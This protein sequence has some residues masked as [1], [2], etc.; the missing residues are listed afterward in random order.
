MSKNNF[1]DIDEKLHSLPRP[2]L[3]PEK[4]QEILQKINQVERD[5]QDNSFNFKK[6]IMGSV[7]GVGA[8]AALIAF[9]FLI[10][11][12]ETEPR[13]GSEEGQ[14]DTHQYI[15]EGEG[16]NWTALFKVVIEEKVDLEGKHF[17]ESE[18]YFELTY[19]RSIDELSEIEELEFSFET[20]T[21]GGSRKYN[22]PEDSPPHRGVFTWEGE[23]TGGLMV[24]ENEIIEVN[25]MWADKEDVFTI[26]ANQ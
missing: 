10:G 24:S 26:E 4:K 5:K 25:V 8:I 14:H 9:L 23:S 3:P 22:F 6:S 1:K 13:Q 7:A 20:R 11:T 12:V 16:K 18:E 2:T 17:V 15:F 19:K 21:G